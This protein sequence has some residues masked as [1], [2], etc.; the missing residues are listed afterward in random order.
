[1]DD[2]TRFKQRLIDKNNPSEVIDEAISLLTEFK[3]F[4]EKK[5]KNFAGTSADDFYEFSSLL[6]KENNNTPLAYEVFIVF[7]EFTGNKSLVKW[8][9]EVF[10]G[11]EVMNNLSKRLTEEFGEETRNEIFAET[12]VPPLGIGP[13]E[14]PAYTKTLITRLAD[15]F[16][17]E[18]CE[19]FLIKGLR[20]PYTEWRK[21][22]REKYLQSEN[23]DEFMKK[24]RET[25]I[26]ALEKHRD[27]N[28]LFFTQEINDQ[29]VDY[30]RNNPDLVEGGVRKGNVIYETKIPHETIKFLNETDPRMKAYYYCHCPWVKEAIK[31]GTV[32]EI[33]RVFCNCSGGYYKT[34]WEIVLEQPVEA[35]VLNT[36]LQGDPYCRFAL[37]LPKEVVKDLDE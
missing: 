37:T 27:E 19:R 33:P 2:I 9:R 23:L 24:K 32:T 31:D 15:K 12:E 6:I 25:F 1:M 20:D 11:H 30:V 28:T 36:V 14:K 21:P 29:V 17:A 4:L 18:T 13:E 22:D 26:K 10:D 5:K 35:K 3:T 8:G 7:G 16:D 34:Y